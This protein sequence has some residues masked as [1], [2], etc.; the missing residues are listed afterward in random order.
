MLVPISVEMSKHSIRSGIVSSPSAC[1]SPSSA[2][3]R[4]WRRRSER[5][6]SWSIASRA[7]RSASSRIRRLSPRS[8]ARISTVAPAARARAPRPARPGLVGAELALDDQQR[9]HRHRARVVL[10]DERLGDV[11]DLGVGGVVEVEALA[12]GEHAV[13]DLED[14]GVGLA[15]ADRD[16]DRVERARAVV[17]DPLALEQRADRPQAV[18][19][20]GGVL[21]ALLGRGQLHLVLELAL[22]LLVAAGQEGD[23]A[24]DRRA[25]LL[26]ADVADARRLAALDVVVQARRAAAPARARGRRRS[27]T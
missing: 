6:F 2:S 10:E 16:R 11:G 4:C 7:L 20:A 3:T 21:E 9:R 5:S 27:G 12:V 14:L 23:H 18:A 1:W 8:A 13:A 15:V 19:L 24:V 22:D 26:L 17:G 25:V